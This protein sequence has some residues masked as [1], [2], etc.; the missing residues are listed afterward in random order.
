MLHRMCSVPG[1]TPWSL[2]GLSSVRAGCGTVVHFTEGTA[3]LWV[4]QRTLPHS[5]PILPSLLPA[6]PQVNPVRFTPS[7]LSSFRCFLFPSFP[8]SL[9]SC[10]FHSTDPLF[11]SCSLPAYAHGPYQPLT[12]LDARLEPVGWK[13]PFFVPSAPSAAGAWQAAS[14]TPGFVVP[15]TARPTPP[16]A[17]RYMQV[18]ALPGA[19]L[20]SKHDSDEAWIFVDLGKEVHT[21]LQLAEWMGKVRVQASA[22]LP[23][24]VSGNGDASLCARC[25]EG[26]CSHCHCTRS[27]PES[28][29]K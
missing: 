16:I 10:A 2:F 11:S 23:W 7:F 6:V 5:M 15:L 29:C 9:S 13:L 12:N 8:F 25:K 1:I 18:A 19:R 22:H 17:V 26:S 21:S 24:C 20:V 27:L 14:V 4:P 28:P 3:F